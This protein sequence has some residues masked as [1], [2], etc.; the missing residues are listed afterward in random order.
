MDMCRMID[1]NNDF[2]TSNRIQKY[3]FNNIL[4]LKYF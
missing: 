1:I 3:L 2:H 4:P